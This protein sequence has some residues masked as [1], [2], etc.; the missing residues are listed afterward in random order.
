MGR[1]SALL[2]DRMCRRVELETL[3]GWR[4]DLLAPLSGEVLEIG[5]GTG[6]NL[7]F[8][9]SSV[10]SVI[11]S[12][13]DPHMRNQLRRKLAEARAGVVTVIDA[14]VD[15]LPLLDGSV[16]AVVATLVLCSVPDQRS[17]LAEI[18]RVLRPSGQFVFL[19]HV[20]AEGRPRLLKWQRRIEPIWKRLAGNCHLTRRTEA[21]IEGS[22][23]VLD[24]VT[25]EEF[26]PAPALVR[27]SIRGVA[28][29]PGPGGPD[30]FGSP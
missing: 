4:R 30:A 28:R 25:R 5:S 23:L 27:T 17:A 3:G 21:A 20:A 29:K 12:E 11:L 2:Y 15:A 8:Y 10:A 1:L 9:P 26:Y 19:E 6:L 18:H 22:G 14:S 13:P 7:P 16:D 24:R